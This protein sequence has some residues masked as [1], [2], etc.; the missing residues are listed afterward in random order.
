MEAPAIEW[1]QKML[2][3]NQDRARA[4]EIF[5][6]GWWCLLENKSFGDAL[7]AESER[8]DGWRAAIDGKVVEM[9]WLSRGTGRQAKY[10]PLTLKDL[11]LS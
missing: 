5:L 2:P 7:P 6:Q 8:R 11:G 1:L 9:G 3:Q 4:A 10:E